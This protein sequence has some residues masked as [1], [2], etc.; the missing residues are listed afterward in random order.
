MRKIFTC[1]MLVFLGSILSL[2]RAAD[3]L[4]EAGKTYFIKSDNVNTNKEDED[5]YLYS[6]NGTL[7]LSVEKG[8][9]AYQW[10]CEKNGEYFRF[11]NGAGK[12][13]AFT[14]SAGDRNNIVL[15]DNNC[16]FKIDPTQKVNEGCLP[17]YAVDAGKYMLVKNGGTAFNQAGRTYDKASS[18]DKYSSDYIFEEVKFLTITT[19]PA[20]VQAEISWNGATLNGSGT[21]ELVGNAP[22]TDGI[23]KATKSD[24]SDLYTLEGFY[25]GD[26]RLG[27][28][29]DISELS[30]HR[31]ITAKFKMDIYSQNYGDK[32]IRITANRNPGNLMNLPVKTDYLNAVPNTATTD[33]GSENQIWCFVGNE[34]GFKI[35][36]RAAGNTL[37]LGT[38]GT[39]YGDGTAT[40]MVAAENA[41]EWHLV[42]KMTSNVSGL[43]IS[44]K[45]N[46]SY[47]LNP[48]GGVGKDLKLYN[49][50]ND[51][52]MWG[53][54][55]TGDQQLTFRVE[56]EGEPKALNTKVGQLSIG[57]GS[58][59]NTLDV[60][61]TQ[62]IE[63]NMYLMKGT[64]LNLKLG[65][66]QYRGYT[67]KGFK[68][69]DNEPEKEITDLPFDE[70]TTNITAVYAV[71]EN[72]PSQYL[73]Y[74]PGKEGHPYRIPA[75]TTLKNGNILAVADFRWDG[76]DIGMG[77][78]DLV[79]RISKDNGA[80][81]GDQ[82][83]IAEGTR[84]K[85]DK[86]RGYG[87]AAIVTDRE[88]GKVLIM[89][90]T[91]SVFY[92]SGT[93]E[94]PLRSARL[95]SEDNGET[96]SQPEDITDQMYALLPNSTG[97][98]IGAGK[99]CQS[100][101]TKVGNY[102]RLYAALCTRIGN[103][104]IYSD[105]FGQNWSVLGGNETSCA[106]SGDEPKCEELPDGSVVL[107]SRKYNGRYFNIYKFTDVAS[108]AGSWLG[109][110][111]SNDIDGGLKFNSNSTNGEIQLVKVIKNDDE[112]F[113]YMMIQSVPYGPL[114]DGDEARSNVSIF[115]KVFDE[116]TMSSTTD[117]ATGW[118]L[119][120]QFKHNKGAYSTMCIQP[121]K[122]LG[123]FYEEGPGNYCMV[124]RPV[125]IE[126]LTNGA[127]TMYDEKIHGAIDELQHAVEVEK[128][129]V[130]AVLDE[131][132]DRH[133][134][135]PGVGECTNETYQT[136]QD[137]YDGANKENYL[138]L[139]DAI[140]TLKKNCNWPIF[141][142]NNKNSDYGE[143]K[144]I[145]DNNSGTLYF[146]TTD[147]K[148]AQMWWKFEGVASETMTN[149]TYV[150]TNASTN[151]TFWGSDFLTV[152]STNP[153]SEGQ[154]I[155]KTD[156][157]G[158]P[159]HAQ[160]NGA[161]IVRYNNYAAN[162][163]SAWDFTYVGSSFE[164]KKEIAE[165]FLN[166]VITEAK[167]KGY[168]IGT[169]TGTYYDTDNNYTKALEAAE[170]AVENGLDQMEAEEIRAL[171]ENLKN[172]MSQLYL[173]MPEAGKFYRFKNKLN[174]NYLSSNAAAGKRPSM[175]DGSDVASTVFYLSADNRLTGSNLL[176]MS[177]Y[178]FVSNIGSETTFRGS[179]VYQGCYVITN[180][181]ASF[182]GKAT[183]NEVDR[184]TNITEALNSSNCAWI[185]EEVTDPTQ[186]FSLKKE[187]T[188]EYATLAAPVALNIPAGVKA[189][190]VTVNTT[191]AET[192][193]KTAILTEVTDVIP[194]GVAVVLK[195]TGAESSFNFT[196]AP[197]GSTEN[198][199]S[200]TGVYVD[201]AIPTATNA[202]I[203]GNKD[204][205]IGFYQMS[206]DDR[207]LAAH[208]AYLI[209]PAEASA[210]RSII[211]S[212]GTTTDIEN[213][214]AES[215][216]NEEYYDL[217]GRR[218]MNPTK[219]IYI[220][221]SGKKVVF[222][223]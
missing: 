215:A 201:T 213:T 194:A 54:Q 107:S 173:N 111:S 28:T 56:I 20:N 51:G 135:N 39:N 98:F 222:N 106:P 43:N 140:N 223:K 35:Y 68:I 90:C 27:E 185:L 209:L 103:Y 187:M 164:L 124:Y 36:N 31:N 3:V 49:N 203:L 22:I 102:Y 200:L 121:D 211:F 5:Y 57:M 129:K 139:G 114:N 4:P 202:Y 218:V 19:S 165:A 144:S 150:V 23:L 110:V 145:Y 146:K 33:L 59:T 1:M 112:S 113:H 62:T 159:V 132:A 95:Y 16:D 157:T 87:D 32:W 152:S 125:S 160:E 9:T 29:V 75:I 30:G 21:F 158:N 122:N 65:S 76:A 155:I 92:S 148:D 72:D 74:T 123:F 199:N 217:Q 196:L 174:N 24:P 44:P 70:N 78:V 126:Q 66:T 93:R 86:A 137:A 182:Y 63:Q 179:S 176:N 141:T 153:V 108:A 109:V 14:N 131:F 220:T 13:L 11:K 116:Y 45:G 166:T 178:T 34:E 207:T 61:T 89:C 221:R 154:F 163:G 188:A 101:V 170:T 81:W 198:E 77:A 83:N 212:D 156:G 2:A 88:S 204:N 47:G 193:S 73:F 177:N 134:D 71:D 183:G 84:I 96:W 142:I 25:E 60:T 91:G 184:L 100:R 181:N 52:N 41:T 192:N 136:L 85:D 197:E 169:T 48:Y 97:Q 53:F 64:K 214:V 99:I 79:G 10:T 149:G 208:K 50:G 42:D 104:V 37:A 119:G 115:Y 151:E 127:Y 216:E 55:L 69:G 38:E 190:T 128:A 130:K 189:Y 195:K 138:Q 118:N 17:L 171:A 206:T 168:V 8:G 105:D 133:N 191:D 205:Q 6:N 7:A 12:Y 40:K 167:G 58:S 120:M 219:G 46:D 26:T 210:I 80:T 175:V 186:Q 161:V 67:F 94:N 162:S 143:G 172:A 82:F 180:S 117:I 147:T 15:S 18:T